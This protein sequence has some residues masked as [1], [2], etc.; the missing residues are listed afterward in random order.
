V[1]KNLT[2]RE[3]LDFYASLYDISKEE[4]KSRIDELVKKFSLEKVL[5]K[6]V[7][8]LSGGYQR[9]VSI[10]LAIISKPKILFLDEPTLGLDVIAR[11]ELWNIIKELKKNTTIIL[12]THYLEEA[13][14]LSDRVAIMADGKLKALDTPENI[15]KGSDSKNFEDAFI[16]IAGGDLS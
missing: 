12:T 11:R 2:V 3:N 7:K 13:E 14:S 4:I 9:K 1:A 5:D 15:I 6:R 10:A 8:K 16:K